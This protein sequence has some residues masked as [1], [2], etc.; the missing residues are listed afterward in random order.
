MNQAKTAG[1]SKP[2][3]ALQHLYVKDIS[4]ESPKSP[5]VFSGKWDPETNVELS[6]Q[7]RELNDKMHEV[8]LTVTVTCKTEGSAAYIVEVEQAGI[9]MVN[10]FSSEQ[11]EHFLAVYCPTML[12]PYSREVV[13]SM[14]VKGGF[15]PIYL[16][17]FNFEELYRQ[18]DNHQEER[19][20]RQG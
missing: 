18:R 7:S 14:I 6:S 8:V 9:F 5:E 12:F 17:P 4:F 1:P 10:N 20:A 16:A 13:S 19:L 15:A 3:F 11:L 2:E